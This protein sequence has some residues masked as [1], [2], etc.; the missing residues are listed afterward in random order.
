MT[1][2]MS[3]STSMSMSMSEYMSVS[4]PSAFVHICVHDHVHV[5]V[6]IHVHVHVYR[7]LPPQLTEGAIA[8]VECESTVLEYQ[9]FRTIAM[10]NSEISPLR[11]VLG[12]LV[13]CLVF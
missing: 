7:N 4:M 3:M 12:R 13:C 5:R 6:N 8:S 10:L 11:P 9:K 1:V 2:S